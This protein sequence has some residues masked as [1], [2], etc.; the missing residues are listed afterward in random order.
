MSDDATLDTLFLMVNSLGLGGLP[1]AFPRARAGAPLAGRILTCEQGFKP[2]ADRLT[3]AGFPPVER[4]DGRF[5]VVLLLPGRQTE[6]AL[7]DF[8][9]GLDLLEPG[10]SL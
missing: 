7:A 5:P 2:E 9:R 1:T 8:A 4:L 3:A 10:G 6:E